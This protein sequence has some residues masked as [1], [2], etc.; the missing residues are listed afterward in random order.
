VTT[1][2]LARHGETDWN[3]QRRWQGH[4]DPPLNELGRTQ[5]QAMAPALASREVAAIYSSDL[6]RANETA[7]I[8]AAALSLPV[9]ADPE[10]RE[11]DVGEWSGLTTP[12][13]E[14]RFPDGWERHRAGEDGWEQ[15]E[16][17][18][19]MQ[20]R[21]VAAATRIAAGHRSETILLV[22]H[23]GTIRALLAHADGV[24]LPGFGRSRPPL[25]NG[26]LAAVALGDDGFRRLD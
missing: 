20:R 1:L 2:L 4:A 6:R 15:G 14:T 17:H 23:G 24:P 19:A 5:A 9:T 18:A 8:V 21:I 10:L 12:E 11:I 13:I 7:Q 22:I 3:R 25:D 26:S 16:T